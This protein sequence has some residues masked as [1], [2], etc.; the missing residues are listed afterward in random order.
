MGKIFGVAFI[1]SIVG[2][3]MGGVLGSALA[4]GPETN[5]VLNLFTAIGWGAGGIVGALAGVGSV[6]RDCYQ[7]QS[8]MPK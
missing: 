2:C 5:L 6:L 7:T 3:L 1:T 8:K 4:A